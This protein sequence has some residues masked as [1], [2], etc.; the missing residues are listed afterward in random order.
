MTTNQNTPPT[1]AFTVWAM[2]HQILPERADFKARGGE[3]VD[4]IS[5]EDF[6]HNVGMSDYRNT[7]CCSYNFLP[8]FGLWDQT[9]VWEFFD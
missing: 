3:L 2:M 9:E 5:N 4:I 1:K 7:D 8:V 6:N